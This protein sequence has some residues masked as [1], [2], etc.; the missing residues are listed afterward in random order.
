MARCPPGSTTFPR[1][2]T[3]SSTSISALQDYRPS[4]PKAAPRLGQCG[5]TYKDFTLYSRAYSRFAETQYALASLMNP[6]DGADVTELLRVEDGR[7]TLLRNTWF[8]RLRSQGYAIKVYQTDRLDMCSE[9]TPVDSCYTYSLYSPNPVQRSSVQTGER[10]RMLI[11]KLNF[12]D[13]IPLPAPLAASEALERFEKD[14]AQTPR[15][16]A[17]VVHLLLPHEGFLYRSDCSIRDPADWEGANRLK[18]LTSD[19]RTAVY[20]HYLEH[21]VC[22]ERRINQLF[23]RLRSLRVYDDATIVVHGDHG[24]R[25]AE[26]PWINPTPSRLSQRDLL[27]HFSTLFAVKAPG[28]IPGVVEEPMLIQQMF[29]ALFLDAGA[30]DSGGVRAGPHS[31]LP[32]VH[33]RLLEDHVAARTRCRRAVGYESPRSG[34]LAYHC[35]QRSSTMRHTVRGPASSSSNR[36]HDAEAL[37]QAC[38]QRTRAARHPAAFAGTSRDSRRRTRPRRAAYPARRPRMPAA[39]Q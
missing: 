18:G 9:P 22:T 36:S 4:F 15:G 5:R 3:L 37:Q 1:S 29:A 31:R 30:G 33:L 27:D 17:Y 34:Q 10:L 7:Y 6:S 2:S 14:I 19:R 12:G 39:R 13:A 21:V 24:S 28:S 38:Q 25:I 8:D 26:Q 32:P 20:Q 11:R 35:L 23:D 16:V